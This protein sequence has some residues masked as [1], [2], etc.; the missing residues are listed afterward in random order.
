MGLGI[1]AATFLKQ[2]RARR[3]MVSGKSAYEIVSSTGGKTKRRLWG[4]PKLST[5]K[6]MVAGEMR[7]DRGHIKKH[8][9]ILKGG[10]R[11]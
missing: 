4:R 5:A 10:G 2:V 9:P 7:L 6:K 1:K 8:G 11:F 3:G